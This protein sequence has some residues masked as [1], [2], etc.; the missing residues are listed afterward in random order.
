V[1]GRLT[2]AQAGA[3]AGFPV[4]TLGYVPAGYT[5]SSRDVLATAATTTASTSYRN[6]A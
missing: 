4:Y 3:Q 1:A 6:P 5:L 2:P